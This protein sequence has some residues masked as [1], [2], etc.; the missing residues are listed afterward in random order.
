MEDTLPCLFTASMQRYSRPIL[1]CI[2]HLT[3]S[4]V[5]AAKAFSK[6]ALAGILTRNYIL[7]PRRSDHS[8]M[9][10]TDGKLSISFR[11]NSFIDIS[12]RE[13]EEHCSMTSLAHTLRICLF[14]FCGVGCSRGHHRLTIRHGGRHSACALSLAQNR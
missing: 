13:Q 7:T 5:E 12:A 4:R 8:K 14:G 9:G 6:A 11:A 1:S 2:T 3:E 10:G